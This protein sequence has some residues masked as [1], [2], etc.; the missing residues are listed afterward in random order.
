MRK[1]ANLWTKEIE[2]IKIE[3]I[4]NKTKV[5]III[6]QAEYE[7]KQGNTEEDTGKSN[8]EYIKS[9][10]IEDKNTGRNNKNIKYQEDYTTH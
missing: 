10:L 2:N 9:G 5:I 8:D 3:A 6:L 7:T 1:L 4:T